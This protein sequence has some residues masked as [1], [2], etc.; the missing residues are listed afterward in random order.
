MRKKVIKNQNL[1]WNESFLGKVRNQYFQEGNETFLGP[2][3]KNRVSWSAD[4]CVF[5]VFS[6]K[7]WNSLD[8]LVFYPR[9]SR[10]FWL[11][12]MDKICSFFRNLLMRKLM[13]GRKI[14]K[15]S[16]K[17]VCL[18]HSRKKQFDLVRRD[19]GFLSKK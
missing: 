4:F 16:R 18:P 3:V 6:R 11:I 5:S 13:H 17:I 9:K 12:I 10:P 8:F 19:F 7:I 1:P 2:K 15:K 14:P